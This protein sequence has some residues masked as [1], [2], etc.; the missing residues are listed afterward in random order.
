[1]DSSKLSALLIIVAASLWGIIGIFS[2]LLSDAGLTSLQTTEVRCFITAALM[3]AVV[4]VKDRSLFRIDIRDLWMFIGTG[5]FSIVIFN[6]LYF[7]TAELVSL[8]MTAVLLYTAPCFVMVLS[9]IIFKEAV[10]R[11]KVLALVL[12]FM[13]C[14]FTAGLIGGGEDFNMKGFLYGLGSG[15]MYSLYTIIGKFALRKYDPMTLT[16]YTFFVAACSL[17]FV[18]DPGYILDVATGSTKALL[19]MLGLGIVIT[20]VPYFLYS[21]GLKGLDAGKASVIAFIEPMVATVAGIV[22]YGETLTVFNALGILLILMSVV[23]LNMDFE[24]KTQEA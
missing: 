17:F 5:F 11:Q 24:K 14:I 9:A 6:V 15:A 7:E 12:A 22:V 8:S 4:F 3:A 20:T 21:K 16:F 23:L 1:M 19:G 10:T 2:R 18:S 13:G